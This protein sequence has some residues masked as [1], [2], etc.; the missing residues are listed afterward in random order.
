MHFFNTN[1]T[2]SHTSLTQA[3]HLHVLFQCKFHRKIIPLSQPPKDLS[4]KNP[5]TPPYAR[6]TQLFDIIFRGALHSYEKQ[7]KKQ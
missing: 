5:Q 4:L 6:A 1:T 7:N 3:A 2:P